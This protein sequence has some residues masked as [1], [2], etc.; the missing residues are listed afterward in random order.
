[1]SLLNFPAKISLQILKKLSLYDHINVC[2]AHPE[3]SIRSFDKL[4]ATKPT[5][6][7]SLKNLH[8]LYDQSK[9]ERERDQCFNPKILERLRKKNCNE[10]IRQI[11]D[12]R[13]SQFF[14][15]DEIL[16]SFKG[17]ITILGTNED[18]SKNFY[19]TLLRFIDKVEGNLLLVFINVKKNFNENIFAKQCAEIVSKKLRRGDKVFL[20]DYNKTNQNYIGCALQVSQ[21]VKEMSN[22]N[23]ATIYYSRYHVDG[24]RVHSLRVDSIDRMANT[25]TMIDMMGNKPMEFVAKK[26][27]EKVWKA[28]LLASTR[29]IKCYNCGA[30]RSLINGQILLDTNELAWLNCGNCALAGVCGG[31]CAGCEGCSEWY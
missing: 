6:T 16:H 1:M 28:Q 30:S 9:T 10:V 2:F 29:Y 3:L 18:F 11:M 21:I 17:K 12:P 13:M 23:V 24:T 5:A 27:L 20:V 19:Q 22:R 25:K 7:I 26:H 15:N 8:R 31:C 4:L 14:A